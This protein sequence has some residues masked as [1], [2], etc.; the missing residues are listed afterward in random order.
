MRRFRPICR[1]A[2]DSPW[3]G[4]LLGL[5]AALALS[6]A[7]APARLVPA[8]K[9]SPQH[10]AAP[11]LPRPL[12]LETGRE[13][14][15]VRASFDSQVAPRGAGFSSRAGGRSERVVKTTAGHTLQPDFAPL[16]RRPP[17]FCS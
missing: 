17:P 15:L 1:T 3:T 5:C 4:V 9:A 2:L 11:C 7:V 14:K 16:Y 12:L 13:A 6:L 10:A 8:E